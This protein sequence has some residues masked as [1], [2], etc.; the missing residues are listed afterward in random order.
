MSVLNIT[1]THTLKEA[2]EYERIS[3]SW[4]VLTGNISVAI[5]KCTE[6]IHEFLSWDFE[7]FKQTSVLK[8]GISYLNT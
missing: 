7:N 4:V 3:H 8:Q 2:D 1:L 6:V 5:F